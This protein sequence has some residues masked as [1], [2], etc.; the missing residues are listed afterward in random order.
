[1]EYFFFFNEPKKFAENSTAFVFHIVKED[2]MV[3]PTIVVF[4]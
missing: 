3:S 1:M 4:S 2:G